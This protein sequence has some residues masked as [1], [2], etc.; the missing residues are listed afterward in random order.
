MYII[1]VFYFTLL[2]FYFKK[3]VTFWIALVESYWQKLYIYQLKEINYIS[4]IR[5]IGVKKAS[6]KTIRLEFMCN[7]FVKPGR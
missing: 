5:S 7:M 3:F 2:I 4:I 1:K 6:N